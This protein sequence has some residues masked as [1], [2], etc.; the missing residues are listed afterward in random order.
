LFFTKIYS[1]FCDNKITIN[2]K[3]EIDFNIKIKQKRLSVLINNHDQKIKRF[4]FIVNSWPEHV[5]IEDLIINDRKVEI[6]GMTT[7]LNKLN[8]IK[9]NNQEKIII[10]SIDSTYS[11]WSYL[12]DIWFS[13]S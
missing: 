7:D 5:Y 8:E 13:S 11:G 12:C 2:N 9:L 1:Y 10:Q 6:K 4:N 3:Q